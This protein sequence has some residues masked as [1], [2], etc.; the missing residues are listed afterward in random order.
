MSLIP[1]RDGDRQNDM[2]ALT[3]PLS[4]RG[5]PRWV[6]FMMMAVG[7]FYVLNPTAGIVE[8]IPDN[9]P[10]IGNLDEGVAFML[11]WMGLVEIFEGKKY[12]KP[13]VVDVVEAKETGE[14][15]QANENDLPDEK[16]SEEKGL[17]EE[18]KG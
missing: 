16:I 15:V 5:W 17:P 7:V 4:V 18:E 12:Q 10:I 13:G 2:S 9:F 11:I 8:F 6:V 14:P 3:T 1:R